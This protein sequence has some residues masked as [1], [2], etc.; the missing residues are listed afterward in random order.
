ML[1][2]PFDYEPELPPSRAQSNVATLDGEEAIK[3]I[4]DALEAKRKMMI[5]M[6]LDKADIRIDGEFLRVS[7]SPDNAK[8]KMQLDGRDRRQ[9]IEETCREV[10]GR[11]LTLSV[12][13]GA[14]AQVG[15]DPK[16]KEATKAKEKVE[17]NNPKVKALADKFR[18][19][20]IEIIK[21]D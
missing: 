20:S 11:R 8:D 9:A 7:L 1:D 18:A 5:V 15:S 10:L 2:D 21:P 19:E 17:T 16:R 13:V 12:S 6:A 4:K 14:E 3:R